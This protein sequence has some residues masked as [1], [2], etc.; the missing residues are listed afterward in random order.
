MNITVLHVEDCPSL[1]PLMEQ[2][3]ELLV[4]RDDLTLKTRLVTSDS[5][6]E[7]LGFH[8]SPTILI[9]GLDPFP[10]PGEP[11]GLSCR[12]SDTGYGTRGWPTH[13][14]LATILPVTS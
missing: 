12:T 6:A 4:G 14:Q 11:V 2:L 10:S 3:A 13:A 5:D 8:G 9:D 1:A 7:Q